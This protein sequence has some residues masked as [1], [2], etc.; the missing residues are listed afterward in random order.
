[1]RVN[2]TASVGTFSVSNTMAPIFHF[3]KGSRPWLTPTCGMHPWVPPCDGVFSTERH[4]I[5]KGLQWRPNSPCSFTCRGI[6]R[7]MARCSYCSVP[8]GR[9]TIARQE[10]ASLWEGIPRPGMHPVS[11]ICSQSPRAGPSNHPWDPQRAALSAWNRSI[12]R[13]VSSISARVSARAGLSKESRWSETVTQS[14]L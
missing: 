13:Q 7:T 3:M 14:F 5:R 9:R 4:R 10:D 1:M 6:L 11:A 8:V 2:L 12:T